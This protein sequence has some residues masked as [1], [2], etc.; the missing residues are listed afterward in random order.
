MMFDDCI[1]KY[2]QGENLST[3]KKIRI[4]CSEE[5]ILDRTNLLVNIV[6]GKKIIDLGCADHLEVIDLKIRNN[7][8]LHKRLCETAE[9]CLGIDINEKAIEYIKSLGYKDVLYCD[10]LKDKELILSQNN[11]YDIL[12]AGET[13]EHIDNPVLFLKT[14]RELYKE[15]IDYLLISVPNAF[16]IKNFVSVFNHLEFIN[17]DHRYYFTPY[18]LAK[19]LVISGFTPIEFWF[20]NYY[21]PPHRRFYSRILFKSKPGFRDTIVMISKF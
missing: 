1:Y 5:E 18:T 17:T 11:N 14:L 8:W 16:A 10:I 4:S 15:N 7:T 13:L 9:F 21:E 6:R 3:G 2:L 20:V 19:I 12:V